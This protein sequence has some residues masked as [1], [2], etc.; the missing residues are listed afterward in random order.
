MNP[1]EVEHSI[2]PSTKK[3]TRRP[4]MSSFFAQL[5]TI[6]TTNPHAPPAPPEV[7]AAERLLRDQFAMLHQSSTSE[8]NREFLESLMNHLETEMDQPPEKVPGVPQTYLD[9]LERVPK[10]MLKKSDVCPICAEPFLDDPYPLVV[11]LPCHK[12]HRFDLECVGPWL[13]LQGTCPLDRKEMQ[14]KKVAPPKDDSEEE[15]AGLYA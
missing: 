12:N 1:Y 4:S 5:N 14:K 10:K 9:E 13:L 8:D 15:D 7:S 11:V 6:Q 3:P 2:T